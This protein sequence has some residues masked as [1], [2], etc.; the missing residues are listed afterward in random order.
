MKERL[1]VERRILSIA[2]SGVSETPMYSL[3]FLALL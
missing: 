1:C 3:S 2:C